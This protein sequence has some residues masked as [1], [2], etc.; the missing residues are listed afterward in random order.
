MNKVIRMPQPGNF[1]PRNI[2][3]ISLTHT[4]NAKGNILLDI[5]PQA[6]PY[7]WTHNTSEHLTP[8]TNAY[9]KIRYS[10]T[11]NLREKREFKKTRILQHGKTKRLRLYR[12]DIHR[13]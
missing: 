6:S 2:N 4:H 5:K 13:E 1:T 7:K 3:R 12:K 10:Q 8:L 9:K 11:R